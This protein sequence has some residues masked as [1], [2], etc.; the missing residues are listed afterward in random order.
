MALAHNQAGTVDVRF[1]QEPF[2]E[3][4]IIIITDEAAQKDAAVQIGQVGGN[5]GCPAQ[6]RRH[7]VDFID[8]HRC[9]R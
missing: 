3:T 2:Q 6:D 5:V 8:G 4:G 1:F 7:V 9:F